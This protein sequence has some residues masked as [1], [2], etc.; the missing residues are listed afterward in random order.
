MSDVETACLQCCV[1]IGRSEIWN[2][3]LPHTRYWW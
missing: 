3:D 2:S 1:S